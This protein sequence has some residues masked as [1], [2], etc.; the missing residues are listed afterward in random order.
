MLDKNVEELELSVRAINA[1]K[2][3]DI[4]TVGELTKWSS[5]ALKRLPNVGR[6]TVKELNQALG[7]LNLNL[8]GMKKEKIEEK[9][10]E[11]L[12]KSSVLK[13]LN[14]EIITK[15]KEAADISFNKINSQEKYNFNE[16]SNLF[17]E[18][19]NIMNIYR[20]SILNLW[21]K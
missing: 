4:S 20:D 18:H 16:V 8:R 5:Q 9:I 3:N 11:K 14:Y 1:L 15:A 6:Y 21:E 19:Q 7:F 12:E 10:E 13:N 2:N 17:L